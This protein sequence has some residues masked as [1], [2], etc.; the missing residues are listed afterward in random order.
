MKDLAKRLI[1]AVLFYTGL[2]H[3]LLRLRPPA[4]VILGAHRVTRGDDPF[5]P[6]IRQDRFD[7]HI[8]YLARHWRVVPLE[9][10]VAAL[11]NTQAPPPRTVALTFDDGFVDGHT[12]AYPVLR[13]YGV[14]ATF[15]LIAGAVDQGRLPW[16]ERVADLIRRT[17]AAFVA[18]P[19][20]ADGAFP[21]GTER[22][23]LDSLRRILVLLKRAPT[24]TR[25]LALEQLE[26]DLQ[27]PPDE[28]EMLT[29]DQ[30]R[31]MARGGMRFGAHTITHP[32]LPMTG[33]GE[34]K[35]EVWESKVRIEEET[36]QPVRFFA[37]P[38]GDH[39]PETVEI[40]RQAG[41]EAAFGR[42][43]ADRVD[44][45]R[46]GRGDHDDLPLPMFAAEIAGVWTLFRRLL[47]DPG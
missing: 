44:L 17:G 9:D 37:Y 40:V 27:V 36:D 29:W 1:A 47:G 25:E 28:G 32:I 30:V 26:R 18:A 21:L 14:P 45:F 7:A 46:I 6:G 20:L 39:S 38:N 12:L 10:M 22:Q 33:P 3:L 35:R 31:E 4:G 2:L 24:P 11:R 13:R 15:F 42:P 43:T 34:V 8:R 23:R 19:S 5:F 16:P 41:V